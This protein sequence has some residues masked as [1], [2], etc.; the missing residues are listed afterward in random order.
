MKQRSYSPI[1][2]NAYFWRTY[3]QKEIDLIEERQGRLFGYEFKWSAR[4][5]VLPPRLWQDTYPQSEFTV[6][7]PDNYLIFLQQTLIVNNIKIG[8][9]D[10][11][12]LSCVPSKRFHQLLALITLASFPF[13]ASWYLPS[14]IN[15]TTRRLHSIIPPIGKPWKNYG[16]FN[17]WIK[18]IMI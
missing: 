10:M 9:D 2:A 16:G 11:Y 12:K 4:E 13:P 17:N 5:P 7:N 3:N 8:K 1:F 14:R 15:Y 18:T 6:I